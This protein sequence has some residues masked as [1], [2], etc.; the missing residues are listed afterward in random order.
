M[1]LSDFKTS[2]LFVSLLLRYHTSFE[3]RF[4]PIPKIPP[5]LTACKVSELVE[6]HVPVFL[7]AVGFGNVLVKSILTD[8]RPN[9]TLHLLKLEIYK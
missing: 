9:L 7:H 6:Y 8:E 4:I 2:S 3:D 1:C 5:I